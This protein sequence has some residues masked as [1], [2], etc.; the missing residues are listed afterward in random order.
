[1]PSLSQWKNVAHVARSSPI[2]SAR[3]RARKT[4]REIGTK[5][6][7]KQEVF[8][9]STQSQQFG[10]YL[11]SLPSSSSLSPDPLCLS[12]SVYIYIYGYPSISLSLSTL[13]DISLYLFACVPPLG[14]FFL[15][16]PPLRAY[17]LSLSASQF[18]LALRVSLTFSFFSFFF[19]V[20][21]PSCLLLSFYLSPSFFQLLSSPTEPWRSSCLC[22][23][24]AACCAALDRLPERAFCSHCTAPA[25]LRR[26]PPARFMS[27]TGE[28]QCG[29]CWRMYL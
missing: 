20:C 9:V 10:S 11:F 27:H 25:A 19:F 24:C 16:C 1:M 15:V 8:V 3:D 18:L 14:S 26:L 17:R 13:I 5:K 22:K 29:A 12:L 4:R 23:L 2:S 7:S 6:E 28:L 21:T